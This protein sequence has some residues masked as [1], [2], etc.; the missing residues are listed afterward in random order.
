MK[1]I[2][3]LVSLV[4]ITAP[5]VAADS[6][7]GILAIQDMGRVNG[8]AL[9][10]GDRATAG[11]AKALMIRHAPKTRRYGEVF[12][13]ATNAAFLAQG[14][15]QDSCPKPVE[16]AARLAELSGRLQLNLPATLPA[17]Q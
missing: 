10:C 1:R 9:A 17:A 15:D 16:F 14:K 12:E 8:Q 4:L 2:A 11:N 13:E 7:A 3:L 6:D 5:V